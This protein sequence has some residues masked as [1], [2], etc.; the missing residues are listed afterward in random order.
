MERVQERTGE[1]S[2][3]FR[4]RWSTPSSPSSPPRWLSGPRPRPRTSR[5]SWVRG[6]LRAR[7]VGGRGRGRQRG[8]RATA[9]RAMGLPQAVHRFQRSPKSQAWRHRECRSRAQS[10]EMLGRLPRKRRMDQAVL[11]LKAQAKRWRLLLSQKSWS[12]RIIRRSVIIPA[13]LSKWF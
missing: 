13:L 12:F 7:G 6:S 4:S 5:S 2:C 3:L 10:R 8:G 9:A 1:S 11:L